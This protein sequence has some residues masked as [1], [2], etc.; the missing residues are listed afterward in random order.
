MNE[1]NDEYIRNV[2]SKMIKNSVL[3]EELSEQQCALLAEVITVCGLR[4]S[5]FLLEEGHKDESIHV[6]VKGRLEVVKHAGGGS[7]IT[8]HLLKEGEM[9]GELSFI[10]GLEH[11]AALRAV[12]NCEVFSLERKSFE[13]LLSKDPDLIYKVMR[14]IIRT[15]HGILRRMN[16]Q[17][18]EMTNYITKQHGRY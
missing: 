15:V 16:I 5:E 3:G 9:A 10:D 1:L 17:Y 18:V 14:A 13:S 4:E 12:G 2:G 7:W 11:S 8:L 6:I